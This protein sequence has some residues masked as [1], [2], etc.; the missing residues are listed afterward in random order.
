MTKVAKNNLLRWRG[1]N[2]LYFYHP[3]SDCI[4]LEDDFKWIADWGFNFARI[5]INYLLWIKEDDI[6][7]VKEAVLK[8]IDKTV[9]LG[10]KFGI[11]ICLNF[12]YAPG[13]SVNHP[14]QE[15]F[16][17]WRD[18]K[19]LDAFCFHW[20]V[21]AKRYKGIP[22][23]ELSF[24]LVNEPPKPTKERMTRPDHERVIRKVT[25]IIRKV[26]AERLIIADG[27][28]CGNDPSPEL[29]DL[30]IAQSCR[31]YLPMGIS[32]Y[33]ARWAGGDKFPKPVWPGADNYGE[34]W[35]KKH[36]QEHYKNW[37]RLFEKGVGVHCG[38]SGCFTKTPH[39]IFLAWF[40]D[41]LEI[42]KQNQI[43]YALW[44]FRGSFGI[45]DSWRDDVTYKDW[46]GHLLDERLLKL[47]QKY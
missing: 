36:L 24:N 44:N 37:A 25:A 32:H 3:G 2:L 12:H 26:N 42:L 38:E 33:K 47:L 23:S 45:L 18:K 40:E 4:P 1:F 10:K 15:S 9:E 41:V 14:K 5:P 30:K 11:H 7:Q 29:A 22:S 13:Y 39:K 20:E 17:L 35:D 43:G 27:L 16:D 21:F 6:F 28:S 8:Q 31:G 46:H 34:K 19:P